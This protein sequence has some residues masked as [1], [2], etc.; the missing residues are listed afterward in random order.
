MYIEAKTSGNVGDQGYTTLSGWSADDK[1]QDLTYARHVPCYLSD[2][3][4]P[5]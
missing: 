3:L 1:I 5:R 4:S 2:L